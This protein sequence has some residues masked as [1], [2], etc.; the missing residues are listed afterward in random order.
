MANSEKCP[1]CGYELKDCQC[2]FSG[3]AH[4]DRSI[5]EEVVY[6]HLYLFTPKQIQHLIDLQRYWQL[7]YSDDKLKQEYE[8]LIHEIG[9]IDLEVENG[10]S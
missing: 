10:K 4:P 3:S 7:S 6:D 5:R 9:K 1:I 2:L 8:K